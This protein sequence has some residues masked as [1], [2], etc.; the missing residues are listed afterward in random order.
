MQQF[1]RLDT[2]RL[3]EFKKNKEGRL[4]DVFFKMADRGPVDTGS[5]CQLLM[6]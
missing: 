6:G 2:E 3:R 1:P 5:I 4:A